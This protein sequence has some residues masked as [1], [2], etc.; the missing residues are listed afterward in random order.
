M[1]GARISVSPIQWLSV[2][3][4]AFAGGGAVVEVGRSHPAWSVFVQSAVGLTGAA[5]AWRHRRSGGR[6]GVAWGV[7]QAVVVTVDGTGWIGRQFLATYVGTHAS[8]PGAATGT[9][10]ALNAIG[11]FFACVWGWFLIKER[12]AD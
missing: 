3:M 6:L 8:D 11:G 1:P 5:I 9:I 2:L 12:W 7:L 4:A 10:V